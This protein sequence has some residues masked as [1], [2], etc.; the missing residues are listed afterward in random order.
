MQ[1]QNFC[2]HP[3]TH[4]TTAAKTGMFALVAKLLKVA[5]PRKQSQLDHPD[6]K[7]PLTDCRL[8]DLPSVDLYEPQMGSPGG[9]HTS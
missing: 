4:T 6:L 9:L 5:K 1:P 3:T 8:E 7:H 2:M